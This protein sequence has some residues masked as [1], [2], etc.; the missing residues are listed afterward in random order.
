[1]GLAECSFKRSGILRNNLWSRLV[2]HRASP[3]HLLYP[4]YL[5]QVELPGG[6]GAGLASS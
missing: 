6:G 2:Y 5:E 3:N 4:R 1:M